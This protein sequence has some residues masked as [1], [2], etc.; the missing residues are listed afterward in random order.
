MKKKIAI[1]C[2][3]SVWCNGVRDCAKCPF[4]TEMKLEDLDQLEKK[5]PI[6]FEEGFESMCETEFCA[7]RKKED[8]KIK[9]G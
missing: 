8:I 2:N 4:M 7:W 6:Q 1:V 3:Y 9:Q 5:A